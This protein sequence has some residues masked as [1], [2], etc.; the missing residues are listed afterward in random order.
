MY[1]PKNGFFPN[2][3]DNML[4]IPV[5]TSSTQYTMEAWSVK[6]DKQEKLKACLL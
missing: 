2:K 1:F 4:Q 6:K 3:T 5:L